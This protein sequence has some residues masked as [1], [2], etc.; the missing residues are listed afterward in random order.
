VLI[1]ADETELAVRVL[2]TAYAAAG[3]EHVAIM[4]GDWVSGVIWCLRGDDP[5]R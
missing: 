4:R 5:G 3:C 1:D 2:H